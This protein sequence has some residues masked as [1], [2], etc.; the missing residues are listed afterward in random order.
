MNWLTAH[1][2]AQPWTVVESWWRNMQVGPPSSGTDWSIDKLKSDW[3][4]STSA[5]CRRRALPGKSQKHTHTN[6]RRFVREWRFAQSLSRISSYIL[7]IQRFLCTVV[8]L[9]IVFCICEMYFMNIYFYFAHVNC[10]LWIHIF[11]THVNFF[12]EYVN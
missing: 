11:F 9:R 12:C 6:P 4:K 2:S 5:L 7:N 10:F 8:Y 3:L 1:T